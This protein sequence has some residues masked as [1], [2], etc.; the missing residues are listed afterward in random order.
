MTNEQPATITRNDNSTVTIEGEIPSATWEKERAPA[1][2]HFG[3]HVTLDGF[4]KGHIPEKV[5]VQ[6]I[7]E[8]VLLEEMAE[9]AIRKAYQKLLSENNIDAIGR[10]EVVIMK[11]AAGNPLGFKITTAVFP[12]LT[13]PDYSAIA[14][15]TIKKSPAPAIVGDADVEKAIENIRHQVSH[16][17]HHH[18][19]TE[20]PEHTDELPELN[21]E[22][23][24][25]IGDFNDVADFR[26]KVR[27]MLET[28]AKRTASE[29]R[30]LA[31]VDAILEKTP[32]GVP[33]ILVEVELD[34]MFNRFMSD[35]ERMG[36][37]PEDYLNNIKKTK[38]DM[39]KEWRHDAEK[40]AKA[41]VL[42]AEIAKKEN[43]SPSK[44]EIENEV[45]R[46]LAQ[47][48]D[49]DKESVVLY[50]T[51]VLTNQKTLSFLDSQKNK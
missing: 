26:A 38:D 5:L 45:T 6:H 49:A 41:E 35:I 44:E 42:F 50:V 28:D 39:R 51:N 40:R 29:K 14:A 32:F 19:G 17:N 31:I 36:I 4:R 20:A 10:P 1:L 48:P 43:L 7:G 21:D 27:T 8:G 13:L 33:P 37:K 16:A 34:K 12:T 2:V 3:E 22:F 25:K 23:V 15:A 18:D 9:R 47:H 24:K 30:Q 46:L 11:L